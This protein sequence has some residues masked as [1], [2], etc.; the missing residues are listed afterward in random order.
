MRNTGV[1]LPEVDWNA[2][3]GDGAKQAGPRV[4][5]QITK[6]NVSGG[7]SVSSNWVCNSGEKEGTKNYPCRCLR[8]SFGLGT[9]I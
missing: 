2:A 6:Y 7:Y 8:G 5:F 3:E 4:A 9:H 1:V